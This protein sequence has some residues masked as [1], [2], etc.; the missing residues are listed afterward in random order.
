ML[1]YNIKYTIYY[2]TIHYTFIYR[3]IDTL[4]ECYISVDRLTELFFVQIY[5]FL[6]SIFQI[7]SGIAVLVYIAHHQTGPSTWKCRILNALH[8]LTLFNG[9]KRGKINGQLESF[10]H[11][12]LWSNTIMLKSE[13]NFL[14]FIQRI[15]LKF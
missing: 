13:I 6:I 15:N 14:F 4:L 5:V 11:F 8:A 1:L 9:P 10:S 7:I 12:C 3:E 2:N